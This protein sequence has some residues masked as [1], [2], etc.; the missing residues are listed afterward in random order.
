M[1]KTSAKDIIIIAAKLLIIC[2]IVAAIVASVNFITADKIAY[3][4]RVNT[5]EALTGIYFDDY[6]AP[7]TVDNDGFAIKDEENVLI[8]CKQEEFDF[9]SNDVKA[10][11]TLNDANGKTVGFCISVQPMGFKDYIKMLVAV[12]A[13]CTVKGVEIVS[14]SETSGIGTKA[15][16]ESFLSQ[17][18]NLDEVAVKRDVDIISGA[19]KTTKPVIDAVAAS[20][21]EVSEYIHKN[22]GAANEQ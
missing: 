10:L 6:N 21:Y 1:N 2:S 13:D 8:T 22:G 11:Y 9:T 14:M 12:N 20:L 17:F 18:I 3:N 16:D 4:E 19:T 5:A 7:F 15:K